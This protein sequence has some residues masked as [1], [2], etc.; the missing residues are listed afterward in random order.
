M[1]VG[2]AGVPMGVQDHV[3]P[4]PPATPSLPELMGKALDKNC[5]RL[6]SEESSAA[7]AVVMTER[8]KCDVGSDPR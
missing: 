6:H 8:T 3:G 2:K 1:R 5:V 4:G 7:V